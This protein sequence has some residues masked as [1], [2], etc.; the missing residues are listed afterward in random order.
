MPVGKNEII[1]LTE[2]RNKLNITQTTAYH[3]RDLEEIIV[4][5]DVTRRLGLFS[6]VKK[7]SPSV[8][9]VFE[10]QSWV[11]VRQ[12]LGNDMSQ[13]F[14]GSVHLGSACVSLLHRMSSCLNSCSPG[15]NLCSSLMHWITKESLLT[16]A[17]QT[18]PRI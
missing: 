5:Q 15:L 1:L 7:L 4:K 9:T 10:D 18:F 14:Q 13:R 17:N 11:S 16:S 12:D 8:L 6:K 3:H 2:V